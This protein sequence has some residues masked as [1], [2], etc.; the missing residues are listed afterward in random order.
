[1]ANNETHDKGEIR[2][3]VVSGRAWAEFCDA[4]KAAGDLVQQRSISVLGFRGWGVS[5]SRAG[6]VGCRRPVA[7]VFVGGWGACDLDRRATGS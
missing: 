6:A 7:G 3:D 2:D 4:L 5:G 1:M